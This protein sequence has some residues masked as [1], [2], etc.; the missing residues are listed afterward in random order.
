MLRFARYSPQNATRVVGDTSRAAFYRLCAAFT[1][2]LR[3]P[4][5]DPRA[6]TGSDHCGKATH[7][8][9][10]RVFALPV[11]SLDVCKRQRAAAT[12]PT[13]PHRTDTVTI[14]RVAIAPV[15]TVTVRVARS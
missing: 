9:A 15:V 13:H 8:P 7:S 11:A 5:G 3:P 1:H 12:T 6:Q 4:I 2:I 10:Y 14:R